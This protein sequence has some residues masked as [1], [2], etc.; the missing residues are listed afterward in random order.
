MSPYPF[1]LMQDDNDVFLKGI[2]GGIRNCC[3]KEWIAGLLGSDAR[4]PGRINWGMG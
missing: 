2:S 4:E 1:S 3:F